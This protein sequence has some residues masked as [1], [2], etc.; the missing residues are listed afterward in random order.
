METIL[1]LLRIFPMDTFSKLL[2]FSIKKSILIVFGCYQK[3]KK[4]LKK[5]PEI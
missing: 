5:N 2:F 3:K 4:K 1:F